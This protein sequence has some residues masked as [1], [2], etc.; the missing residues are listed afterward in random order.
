LIPSNIY[1]NGTDSK[2][3]KRGITHLTTNADYIEKYREKATYLGGH[4]EVL[5]SYE[6]LFIA[7]KVEK[8]L[9]KEKA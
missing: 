1:C 9:K 7:K 6:D 2:K 5:P 8:F 3:D 4:K